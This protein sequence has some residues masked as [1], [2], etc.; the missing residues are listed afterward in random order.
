[1]QKAHGLV[2]VE[3]KQPEIMG[4]KSGALTMPPLNATMMKLLVDE[5]LTAEDLAR[6]AEGAVI[7]RALAG[8]PSRP[9]TMTARLESGRPKIV[10]RRG[11]PR[12]RP[13]GPADAPPV[14]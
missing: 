12:A 9:F 5:L 7:E 13:P 4:G 8:D 14:V 2:L 10:V 3:G 1:M 6:I 11:Q